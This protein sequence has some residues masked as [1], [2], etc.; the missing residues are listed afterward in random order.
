[1]H[2][3]GNC[4]DAERMYLFTLVTVFSLED[5]PLPRVTEHN[6]LCWRIKK[7]KTASQNA[8]LRH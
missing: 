3:S 8:I 7:K 4:S 1:M 6:D 5:Q 2:F